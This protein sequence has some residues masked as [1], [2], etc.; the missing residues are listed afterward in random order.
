[1][2]RPGGI[3]HHRNLAAR[4]VLPA[5]LCYNHLVQINP[6]YMEGRL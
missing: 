6:S 2:I 3:L 4:L 1:M 5:A